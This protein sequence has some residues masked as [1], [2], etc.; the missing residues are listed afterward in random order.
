[1]IFDH[2][3]RASCFVET[4]CECVCN[5][6]LGAKLRETQRSVELQRAAERG[7]IGCPPEP[8]R[9]SRGLP[10]T[11]PHIENFLPAII[12]RARQAGEICPPRDTKR[13]R[14]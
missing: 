10:P 9:G 5:G 4:G 14:R 11:V 3:D 6:C 7:E 12:R 2:C 13:G 1:M 8:P